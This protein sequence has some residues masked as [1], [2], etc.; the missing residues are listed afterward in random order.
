[1]AAQKKLLFVATVDYFLQTHFQPLLRRASADGFEVVVAARATGAGL[2]GAR[3]I[4]L[5]LARGS[6]SVPALLREAVQLSALVRTESP[7]IVHALSLKPMLLA[8][9]AAR[10]R[11]RALALTGLGYLGVRQAPREQLVRAV[12]RQLTRHAVANSHSILVVENGDDRRWVEGAAAL[13]DHKVALMP[14]A[15]VDPHAFAPSP[16]P[17]GPVT[18]GVVSRLVWSKGVDVAVEAVRLARE[19]G[20]DIRLLIA[21]DADPANPEFVSD[22]ERARWAATPGVSLVGRTNDIAGFWRKAHIACAPTRGGEG[23]PR[24]LL[25]AAACGRPLLTTNTAGCAEFVRDGEMGLVVPPGDAPA[26]ADAL[27]RLA[28]DGALRRRMG[29]AARARVLAG[30]TENHAADRA[31]EV[32]KRLLQPPARSR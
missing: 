18:M 12:F 7:D 1:M 14:G 13:P 24:I 10:D 26:L 22:D 4:D 25:E 30:Y 9:M 19:R 27:L 15:G 17:D 8:M 23:L 11:P 28:R 20:G 16:E 6:M 32:W 29:D 5:P 31:S 2:E 21:G 3:V